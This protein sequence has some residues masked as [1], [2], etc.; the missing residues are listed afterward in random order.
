MDIDDLLKKSRD[1]G[2]FSREELVQMLAHAPDAPE[3]YRIMA[4]ANRIS[5]ALTGNRAE[6]HA[7]FALNLAPCPCN[8]AFCSFARINGVFT[9]ETRISPEEAVARARQ[10]ETD[11][12][13]AVFVMTTAAYPFGLF[14]EISQEV[15]RSLKPETVLVA[16]VGDQS[17]LN[18]R[19]LKD[20]GFAGV[21]HAL[22]LREGSDTGIPPDRRRDSIRA[23]LEAGLQVGTCVEPVGPEHTNEEIA[24]MIL[25]T[26][27][28]NPAYSGAARRIKIPGS[29]IGKRGMISEL[30][31]AQIVAVT[32]L[33]VPRSV[34]GNCTHEPC[35]LGAAAGANLF[36]AE[37]GANPRD[38]LERTE[39][40]RGKTV[41]DCRALFRESG[42]DLLEGPSHF[43]GSRG[44][45]PAAG[46]GIS[47]AGQGVY[48][49]LERGRVR[50]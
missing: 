10:F 6:V 26:G 48:F 5:K 11:G 46:V 47:S 1:E 24:E 32:R 40:G 23:F 18:A 38:T 8:C 41:E 31:M 42:W 16:N 34:P 7:Q 33:G 37:A 20:A 44:C 4:E 45:E 25:F 50:R 39:E 43:Y 49:P 14:L 36:W 35:T 30:R 27:S 2:T 13:N 22:R 19:R 12:A 17:P 29:E 15:R 9:R 21:Y 28:F 3:T